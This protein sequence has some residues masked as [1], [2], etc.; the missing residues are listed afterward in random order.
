M[1]G[2]VATAALAVY[3]DAWLRP[4]NARCA[5]HRRY[6]ALLVR[7]ENARLREMPPAAFFARFPWATAFVTPRALAKMLG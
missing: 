2:D 4:L 6:I 1:C 7:N 3:I 5:Y